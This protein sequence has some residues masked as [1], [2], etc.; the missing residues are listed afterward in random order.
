M[1]TIYVSNFTKIC[2]LGTCISHL[3]PGYHTVIVDIHLK[4]YG[5]TCYTP[6]DI[7]KCFKKP[8]SDFSLEGPI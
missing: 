1:M 3:V 6:I 2:I 5:G 7:K 8:I 4:I